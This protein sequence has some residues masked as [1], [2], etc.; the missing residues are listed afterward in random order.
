MPRARLMLLISLAGFI[1]LAGFAFIRNLID[2]PVYYAAGQS[3]L[4]GRTDL[5]APDFALGRVMDYRYPPVFLLIFWPLWLLPYKAAAYLWYLFS[6]AEVAGCVY[7]VSRVAA[8]PKEKIAPWLVVF[9]AVAPYFINL[10]HYGNAHLLA[11]FLLFAACYLAYINKPVYGGLALAL[12][13]SI[14]LT[15]AI[16]IPYFALRKQWRLLASVAIFLIT[17]N[18]VPAIY[19]GFAKNNELLKNWFAQVVVSQ[20]FHEANGP[21]NL[22]L[23]G[24]LRRTF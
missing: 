12:A 2:F 21:I 6:V 1:T 14:K 22:S 11:I 7:C 10:L 8:L 16:L 9:F 13:I 18:L 19:F 3:L 20:E 23:K 15:P 5:Y 24:Q 17:L 4:S